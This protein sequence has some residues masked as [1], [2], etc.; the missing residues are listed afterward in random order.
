MRFLELFKLLF[1]LTAGEIDLLNKL[2]DISSLVR[3]SDDLA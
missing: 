2:S 3:V 1:G